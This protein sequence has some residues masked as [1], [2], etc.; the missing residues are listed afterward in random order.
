MLPRTVDRRYAYR[1]PLIKEKRVI[2]FSIGWAINALT[3]FVKTWCLLMY[4]Q[5][6]HVFLSVHVVVTCRTDWIRVNLKNIEF[7][8]LNLSF[9][10]VFNLTCA[11]H[12]VLKPG[13]PWKN[14]WWPVKWKRQTETL[15]LN[16]KVWRVYSFNLSRVLEQVLG[17]LDLLN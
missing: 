17:K 12:N 7:V 15:T 2:R 10:Y 1:L 11:K 13:T 4:T 8:Q 9:F 14:W 6:K 16:S 3:T 5:G